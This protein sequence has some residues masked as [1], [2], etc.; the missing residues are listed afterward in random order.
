MKKVLITGASTG[1]GYSTAKILCD[2]GYMVFGSVRNEKDANRLSSEL[3]DNFYPLIF[4]VTNI[5]QI[6]SE[7]KKVK[8]FLKEGECLTG[9]INNAG[10]AL[11]GPVSLIDTAVFRKQFDVNFFGLIDVTKVFLKLLGGYKNSTNQGKIINI[12]SISGLR[13]NPFTAPYC[14][15]KFALEAFSDALRRELMIYGIDVILIEPGPFK[16]E[17]WD[18]AP[19]LENNQFIGSDYEKSL[20]KFY[21][22]VIDFGRKGWNPDII[23]NRIKKILKQKKPATRHIITPNYFSHYFISGILPS[24]F[25]DKLIAK[26]LNLL[27]K[28]ESV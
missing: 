2:S 10:I 27:N 24:R 26:K 18:K 22:L 25:Y 23:G 12:S 15:S 20:K 13:S 28:K 1:I 4:D 9:L 5:D 16:T 8:N 21:K 11:G 17:I 3:G 14:S 7:Y 19:S 6:I